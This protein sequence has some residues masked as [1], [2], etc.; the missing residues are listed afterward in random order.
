MTG[1][2]L[3]DDIV[4]GGED[5]DHYR[6]RRVRVFATSPGLPGGGT[7]RVRT[8]CAFPLGLTPRISGKR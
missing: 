6:L 4:Y 3:H 5:R 1:W 8:R 2:S 7:S